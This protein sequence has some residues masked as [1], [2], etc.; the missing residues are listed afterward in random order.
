MNPRRQFIKT[1]LGGTAGLIALP[2][3][4]TG[5]LF[6]QD[7]AN[8]KIQVV[9]IGC[10][11]MGLSDMKSVMG[12]NLSR[13]VG[14]CD[15]DS[16]RA[17]LAKK[18][19]EE[20]YK[21]KGESG[22]EVKIYSSYQEI[23]ADSKVDAII[24]STPD[25][26]H[27]LI[28]V[29]GAIA[30][31]HIYGQKPLSHNMAEAIA[32]RKAV[33]A[34]KIVF[35]TGSQQRS[36][37]PFP[38]FRMAAEAVLNGRIGKL[39]TVQIGVGIDKKSGKQ[40]TPTAPPA[41]FDFETWLGPAPQVEYVEGCVHPQGLNA[42][43][44]LDFGRPGWITIEDYGLGMITN[45]GAHHIDIAHLAMGQELGGPSAIM[46][47]ADFMKDDMF[48]V[49]AGYHIEMAYPNDVQMILDNSFENGIKFEGDEGWIFC[50]R[51]PAQVTASDPNKAD[52][53]EQK[54]ALRASDEK[55]IGSL[56][57]LT[58]RLPA[59]K[60]HYQNW[61]ECINSGNQPMA[62]VDQ[63]A[64]TQLACSAAWIGMKLGRKVTW[65]SKAENFG[66]DA[67]A[68]ALM[69]RKARKPEYDIQNLMKSI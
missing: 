37:G 61:L 6:G 13:I 16:T 31:K 12:S 27:G 38:A 28:N 1:T 51:G 8:N 41:T 15:L 48:T 47:K 42:K 17:A 52:A 5:S 30:G 25:H 34:K 10:G 63:A 35:Q 9:Q 60:D 65:D 50:T 45:W 32:I 7:A 43:G 58:K 33:M 21:K 40:R 36:A 49:H 64:A 26:W 4:F 54:P 22:V 23:C 69:S 44:E 20:H 56:N 19:V 66:S 53:K 29:A 68:N 3:I 24:N 39:K 62:P 57:T 14:V 59:S 18:I 46:G 11:R 2:N 55:L 67:E